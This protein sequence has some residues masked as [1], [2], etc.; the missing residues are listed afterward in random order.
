MLA[1]VI[2]DGSVENTE[3]RSGYFACL[4]ICTMVFCSPTQARAAGIREVCRVI[5]QDLA[6]VVTLPILAQA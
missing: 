3:K 2:A 1:C 5:K 4:S 6:P